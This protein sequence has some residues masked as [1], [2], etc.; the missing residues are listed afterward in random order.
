M[1]AVIQKFTCQSISTNL[2]YN[3]EH[4]PNGEIPLSVLVGDLLKANFYGVKTLYYNNV[5]D[6]ADDTKVE[7]AKPTVV[8]EVKV[9]EAE[10]CDACSI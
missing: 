8:E 2:S 1:M 5:R 9:E 6:G 4:Y 10:T 3:P 7:D